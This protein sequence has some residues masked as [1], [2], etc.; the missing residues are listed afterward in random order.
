MDGCFACKALSIAVAP[1]ATPTRASAHL[2]ASKAEEKRLETDVPAYK[3][4]RANGYQPKGVNGSAELEARAT[5]RFEI[6]SGNIYDGADQAPMREA[7]TWFEDHTGRGV[8]DPVTTPKPP[9]DA[10]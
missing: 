8:C 1:S 5:T 10:A 4:L 9:E 7:V 3:R 2:F 6:E